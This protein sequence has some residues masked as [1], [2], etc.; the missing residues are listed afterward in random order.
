MR[1]YLLEVGALRLTDHDQDLT[2][3]GQTYQGNGQLLAVRELEDSLTGIPAFQVRVACP[4]GQA[5]YTLFRTD[6]G[7]QEATVH[8]MLY[9][10]GSW[11]RRYAF[12]G[13]LGEGRME[14][15]VYTGQIQHLASYHFQ[16]PIRRRWNH[17][18]QFGGRGSDKGCQHVANIHDLVQAVQWRGWQNDQGR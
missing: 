12:A 13:M 6:Q 18:W 4:P 10:A 3:G 8:L 17:V 15:Y 14:Q 2:Y 7:Y 1:A 9:E 5:S 16:H 11:V